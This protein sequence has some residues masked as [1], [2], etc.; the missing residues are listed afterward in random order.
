MAFTTP[1]Y[2]LTD[3]FARVDRGELQ[4]PDFQRSFAWDIDRIHSLLVTVL[5]GYPIGALLALDTRNEPVRFGSRPILGAPATGEAPGLLLLDGQQRLT[6]VYRCFQGTGL[7]DTV[8]FRSKRITRRFFVDVVRAVAGD[9]L[10]EDAVFAVDEH[11]KVTSHF[12]PSLEQPLTTPEAEA[13]AGCVPV[14]SLL[15]Q[16]GADLLFDMAASADAPIREAIKTFHHS[17]VAPLAA[18]DVPVIRLSRETARAGVGSIFAQ[19]NSAGLQ[20]DVFELLTAV[21][22][23]E[24]PDFSLTSEY[25]RIEEHLARHP[26]L[27]GVDHTAFFTALSLYVT[28][29][30]GRTGGQRED[31][32]TLTLADWRVS[33]D[34]IL[35]GFDRA[36]AFLAERR[37][38]TA[39]QV[40]F[41][42]QLIPLAAIL[43]L[44]GDPSPDATDRLNR[45]FWCGIFGELYGTSAVDLRSSR[46]VAEVT[47]WLTDPGSD[48]PEPHTVKT[49]S[50]SESRLL[51]VRE[52]SAVWQGIYSLLMA[53]GA[54]DWRTGLPFDAENVADLGPMFEPIFPRDWCQAHGIDAEWAD[55]VLNRTP[56]GKRTEVVLQGYDPTRY[57]IRVQA[58]SLME[59]DEFDEVLAT[60]ELDAELLH[61]S[62]AA[63]FFADRRERFIGMVE[64]AMGHPA[65]RDLDAADVRGGAEGPNAFVG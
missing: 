35:A 22:R 4:L 45:W 25:T 15:G 11:G 29:R 24:D 12:G 16:A 60:H 27:G 14:D 34:V 18:Y 1:S 46:D 47:A 50:F 57:L 53:R 58:K 23:T 59:D 64:Y 40:P 36:A 42:A 28:S 44:V 26:V 39:E 41:T 5:R 43:A 2:S 54:R 31:I 51:S 49:S 9:V 3:L 38:F 63:A 52:S 65:E 37:M 10:P 55:S 48:A 30:R 33:A 17:V 62:D 56:M 32:L 21:W 20:M 19:A 6:T 13:A 61:A 7:V 8:D